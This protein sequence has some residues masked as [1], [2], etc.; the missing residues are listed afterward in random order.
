MLLVLFMKFSTFKISLSE[1]AAGSFDSST[2]VFG[3][4][5][6]FSSPIFARPSSSTFMVGDFVSSFSGL[7]GAAFGS[8][9]G[10]F[11]SR[12]V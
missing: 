2:S 12:P 8:P 10:F 4:Y 1:T 5:F 9:I 11:G 3:S 7:K 6:N